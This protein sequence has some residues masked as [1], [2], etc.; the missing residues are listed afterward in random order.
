[1]SDEIR[2][3]YVPLKDV[4]RWP[5]NPRKHAETVIASSIRRFGFVRPLL[6]D[7]RTGVLVAGHGRLDVLLAMKAAGENPPAHVRASESG[8]WLVPVLC[9]ISWKSDADAG[10][11]ALAVN[12]LVKAGGYD[13][14]LLGD[15]FR[16]L[17]DSGA[18]LSDTGFSSARIKEL[19]DSD[20]APAGDEDEDPINEDDEREIV[21]KMQGKIKKRFLRVLRKVREDRSLGS[22][23][24]AVLW[25]L[26]NYPFK[27]KGA[28]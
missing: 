20:P 12:Q 5:K 17:Q 11:C 4:V 14:E 10:Q 23:G 1:M 9:G 27:K 15:V 25:L 28:K 26:R 3:E 13:D 22:N 24:A 21:F 19:L 18:D 7:D 16:E 6:R 2:I 8:D